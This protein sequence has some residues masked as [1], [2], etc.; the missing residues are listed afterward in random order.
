[1]EKSVDGAPRAGLEVS[2]NKYLSTSDTVMDA[3]LKV[4]AAGEDLPVEAAEVLLVD[5]SESMGWAP[6]KIAAAK[7]A[8]A[9]AIDALRDGV[10]FGVVQGTEYAAMVYPEH[11]R[12]VQADRKS[13]HEAKLAIAKLVASGRT[14]MSTWLDLAKELLDQRPDALRHAIL[15]TDGI[16]EAESP[17]QLTR[18]LNACAGHFACDARGIGDDWNPL[19]LRRIAE[20]LRGTA[21]A[22]VEEKELP[23]D[24]RRLTEA[25]MGK[26]V[27]DLRLQVTIPPFAKLRF[28]KQ[29]H[30]SELD[31]TDH[32][33]E[34]GRNTLEVPTGTWGRESR[35][36]H[37]CLEVELA[38]KPMATDLQLGRVNVVE[39][40]GQA[41][42][43]GEPSPILGY[44][45]EDVVLSSQMDEK[46]ERYTVQG[47]LGEAVRAGW[48]AFEQDDRNAAAGHW[49]LALRLATALGNQT[50][51]DRLLPLVDVG[52]DG[53]VRVKEHVRPRDLH[54]AWL[55]SGISEFGSTADVV[56]RE[57]VGGAER[58]CP[59][60]AEFSPPG[61]RSCENCGEPFKET[62]T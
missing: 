59:L 44:V 24:F 51:L 11:A 19:E 10:W 8:S 32:C 6:T 26:T 50:M 7:L 61:S 41:R 3:V 53:E 20:A 13:R 39:V 35:E 30:P 28:L 25:A 15:L 23:A 57:I 55:G 4:T 48:A 45:T 62:A 34:A 58:K 14:A 52:A 38:G 17:E 56:P 29:V 5:C 49:K 54:S 21:D 12:L 42:T 46:V 16:N 31:L 33:V 27:A 43:A 22:V 37:L 2:Q 36:Y 18:T 9:A 60:C 40:A 1:M 47:E